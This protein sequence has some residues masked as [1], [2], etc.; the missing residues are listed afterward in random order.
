[1]VNLG[2]N[3]WALAM[4][5]LSFVCG[6][7]V[8]PTNDNDGVPRGESALTSDFFALFLLSGQNPTDPMMAAGSARALFQTRPRSTR[9]G[10]S[11]SRWSTT[12]GSAPNLESGVLPGVG[13]LATW[14]SDQHVGGSVFGF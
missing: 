13:T 7:E 4:Y 14:T 6:P 9:P 12:F 8:E 5:V 1:M 2:W 10:P 11:R 3:K